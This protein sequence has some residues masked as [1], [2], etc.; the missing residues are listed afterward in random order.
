MDV[1]LSRPYAIANAATDEVSMARV[2]VL[3][4]AGVAGLGAATPEPRVTGETFPLCIEALREAATALPGRSFAAPRD[5]A[6]TLHDT[7]PAAPGARAAIDMALHDAWGRSN[8]LPVVDLLGR[9]HASM[10]TSITIGVRDV[11]DTLA[12]AREYLGR[13]FRVLKVK[14]GEDVDLDVER[15]T[16]LRDLVGPQVPLLADGNVGYTAAALTAFLA[17]TRGLDLQLIEQPL[18]PDAIAAQRSLPPHDVARLVA[19]ESLHDEED[20]ERLRQPLRAFGVFNIKL[21]KCGGITPALGIGRIA[22]GA[23]IGLM[24]GCMD[25]SVI[26]IAAALH[27]AFASQA[28]RWLDLD[29]SFDLSRDF[30]RG[31][32]ELRDGVLRTL[33]RP[34]LGVEPIDM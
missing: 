22:H 32:F 31:G 6:Q 16:K 24:W 18:A 7:M 33:D 30:A 2:R 14:V 12:E 27:A 8:G 23:G 10:P 29:G 28:T 5:L 20:A 9:V 34:G 1:P 17:R 3:T 21:M 13:G 11:P 15:L 26:G 25:E 4:D 19:D